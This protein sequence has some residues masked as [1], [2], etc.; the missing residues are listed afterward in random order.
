MNNL[1][2]YFFGY[3]RIKIICGDVN[4]LLTECARHGLPVWNIDKEDEITV[5]ISLYCQDLA[6][7]EIIL[8]RLKGNYIIEKTRSLKFDF[9]SIFKR[10]IFV[11]GFIII[12]LFVFIFTGFI[13]SATITG[14]EKVSDEEIF[15]ALEKSGFKVGMFKFGINPK[16]I[17]KKFMINYDKLSWIWID[18]NGTKANIS[19]KER[20]PLPEMEDK[21]DYCNCV[22]S[23]DGL[24]VEI[25]PRTGKQIVHPGDVVKKG[26]I[27]IG[28][29]SETKSSNVRY[30][31]ADGIVIAKTWYE[32]S[33]VY[34]HTRVDRYRTGE[35][36][37]RYY[38][39]VANNKLPLVKSKEIIYEKYDFE[40][41]DKKISLFS[42]IYLPISFTIETYYEIIEENILISDDEVVKTAEN[43]L[44]NQLEKDIEN[45]N[46]IKIL[47]VNSEHKKLDDGNIYV[48]VLLECTENIATHQPIETTIL[49][50]EY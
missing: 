20:I 18:I 5:S 21:E 36:T 49:S 25:M 3:Y 2:R 40:E 34:H 9:Y 38:I 27:L 10:K 19:V 14:N 16:E 35:K 26:D 50:E 30:M 37:N 41:N 8:Q 6:K 48:K 28:G 47:S 1:Y 42:K 7:L 44:K 23:K 46:D 32:K 39:N 4:R 33:G 12:S 45:N 11:A 31:H 17:Q 29:I 24:I 15:S 22:A 13:T 43:V